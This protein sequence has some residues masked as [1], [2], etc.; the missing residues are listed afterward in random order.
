MGLPSRPAGSPKSRHH[1]PMP[2]G[3]LKPNS[4]QAAS[5]KIVNFNKL[6]EIIQGPDENPATFLNRLTG[7][8]PVYPIR[9]SL[10]SWGHYLGI[11]FYFTISPRYLENT[12]K[13]RRWSSDPHPGFS[14]ASF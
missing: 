5:N 10:P 13:S 9:P 11:L 4:M 14:Q 8:N 7:F 3:G 12:P 6:K 1:D 2:P